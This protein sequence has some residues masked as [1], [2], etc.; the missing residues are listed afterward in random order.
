[1]ASTIFG[2]LF[3]AAILVVSLASTI[4]NIPPV[5]LTG[6]M[7]L[8]QK[9]NRYSIF[10]ASCTWYGTLMITIPGWRFN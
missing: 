3:D 7:F 8:F 10:P 6:G 4:H 9:R 1:M 5:H 2:S